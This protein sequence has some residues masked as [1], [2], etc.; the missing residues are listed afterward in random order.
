[1][2]EKTEIRPAKFRIGVAITLTDGS[3]VAGDVFVVKGQRLTDLLNDD[4]AFVPV[5]L[6]SGE[7]SV[8]AKSTIASARTAGDVT[9]DNDDPYAVLRVDPRAPNEEVRAAW[10]T[11]V[12]ACHPD[13]LVA[14]DL[15]PEIV[16]AARKVSQRINAAYDSIVRS[17]RGAA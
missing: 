5:D 11:R 1:V 15:D 4:R 12:K 2:F 17:R 6:G 10:M 8:V 7:V 16:Q 3:T 9:A 13:R 14:L